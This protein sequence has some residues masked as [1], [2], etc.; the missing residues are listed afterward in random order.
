M[1]VHDTTGPV[2]AVIDVG[3]GHVEVL[4]RDHA[5]LTVDVLPSDPS[6]SGDVSLAEATAVEFASGRLRVRVPR[7]RSLF[8]RSDSV[9]VR[10]AMPA[11]SS[12]EV[13]SAYGSVRARGPIG[14][15]RI[16]A[17]YGS[18]TADSFAGLVL[19]SPFGTVEIDRVDGDL[20]LTAGHGQVRIGR[21]DGGSRV[22]G[23]HGSI[24][25]G[26]AVGPVDVTTSGPL[27]IDR[28]VGDVTA[29]S[30]HG[31]LRVREVAGGRVA[32]ENSHA[33]VEVGVAPGVAAWLDAAAPHG[34]VRSDLSPDPAA[35]GAG[36]TVELF[37]RS[38]WGDVL[39][40][41]STGSVGAA[42]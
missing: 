34:S 1:S 15:G 32:L 23:S 33:N 10:V 26:T 39:V 30:A 36:R 25:L 27:T 9:D 17:K 20:D 37:L 3:V 28:A 12:L 21:V 11:G 5:G 29:R 14:A 8:G 41:R 2:D 40:R 4:A 38:A 22:R 13:V 31:D 42:S 35:A 6:R 7:R 19:D 16:T 18:V 24:E